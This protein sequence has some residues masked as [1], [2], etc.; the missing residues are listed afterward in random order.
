MI[1]LSVSVGAQTQPPDWYD[2]NAFTF[3][4][5]GLISLLP[6][7][8]AYG[9]GTDTWEVWVCWTPGPLVANIHDPER[10]TK[11]LNEESDVI[12]YFRWLSG[13]R[14]RP[15]F[16]VGGTVESNHSQQ[17]IRWIDCADRAKQA[18]AGGADGALII[19]TSSSEE[20]L[21]GPGE[22][23][24][25]GECGS[26][27]G[28]DRWAIVGGDAFADTY[29]HEIGHALHWPHSFSH[30][31]SWEYDNPMDVMGSPTNDG[32]RE[33]R[34]TPAVNRYAA[35]WIDPDEVATWHSAKGVTKFRIDPIGVSTTNGKQMVALTY[36]EDDLFDM[37]GA[38]VRGGYDLDIPKEG[39]EVYRVDQ[40]A[41]ACRNDLACIS[42]N[43]RIW[44]RGSAEAAEH[45]LGPGE[46]MSIPIIY[47][48]GTEGARIVTVK[49]RV[50]DS[51]DVV[52]GP[53]FDGT[54][55]D[56][57]GS[58]H[59]V[60][61][62]ALAQESITA[63]CDAD[64]DLFC[65]DRP[66]TRAQL[67]VLLIRAT[68]GETT[69]PPATGNVYSD[70]AADAWYARHVEWFARQAWTDPQGAFR[71]SDPAKRA[72]VAEFIVRL[73]PTVA[74]APESTG[75][76]ADVPADHP[77]IRSIESLA[78][79]DITKGCDTDPPRF[80]P[81]KPVTR[82]EIATFLVRALTVPDR[83][84]DV[85]TGSDTTPLGSGQIAVGSNHT[86]AIRSDGTV[87]C[88]G[89]NSYGQLDSPAGTF[90][91]V[92]AGDNYSCAIL[93]TDHSVICW[94]REWLASNLV[95]PAG[96]FI[97][98]STGANHACGLRTD[99]TVTCWGN[100]DSQ[101]TAA[102]TGTFSGVS[103][104]G[105]HSCGI[106][107]DGTAVC[108][109]SNYNGQ[110]DAPTGRFIAIAAGSGY[111]CGIRGI[112]TEGPVTCWGFDEYWRSRFEPPDGRF[113]AI[114]AGFPQTC[115]IRS[116]GT[117]S[118]WG[119]DGSRMGYPEGRFSAIAAGGDQTCAIRSDERIQ[120]WDRASFGDAPVEPYEPF[121]GFTTVTAGNK[122]SCALRSDGR[123]M[124]WGDRV[125][126]GYYD[127]EPSGRFTAVSAGEHHTCG[128][129]ADGTVAC[130]GSTSASLSNEPSGRFADIASGDGHA[131]AIRS[132]G[133][134]VCW[135]DNRYGQL[136]AP[137]GEYIHIT[138]G[139]RARYSCAIRTDG[140][141]TCW[142]R[143][144]NGETIAPSGRYVAIAAGGGHACA[145]RS[146][147]TVSCW[148]DNR[149]GQIDVPSGRF[150]TIAVGS[151][152]S[153]G[154]RTDNSLICWPYQPDIPTG[155]FTAVAVGLSHSCAVHTDGIVTCWGSNDRGQ[156]DPP[157]T[158]AG[159]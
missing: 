137:S 125:A 81:D 62:E 20:G 42:L 28:N 22:W 118:C 37:L 41:E 46:S 77:H 43:R 112:Q 102:P 23:C 24:R 18:S 39:V 105:G 114:A 139:S 157:M 36:T 85:P 98:V 68:E 151:G 128:I 136:S 111:S 82:A 52:I 126:R 1:V 25:A 144:R 5:H 138:S 64:F 30:G 87:V 89:S 91:A 101:Q 124:C 152:R 94:G 60:N 96:A 141:I 53:P 26:F 59:E 122:H 95:A 72:D 66:V 58:V 32:K 127:R 88:A 93:S 143:D 13:D 47:S 33:W 14:Y 120:C 51:F 48:D 155:R 104:G 57:D 142:G 31:S 50:E 34:A 65:P 35:G 80:C 129:R 76:F 12:P 3:D 100:N 49:R 79:A 55:R 44:Q 113:T 19:D 61:I 107:T 133:T 119:F 67:A 17:V 121:G 115:G 29:V 10:L 90:V 7:M 149:S 110:S 147:D 134:I 117:I 123:V 99:R 103:A 38:R 8:S 78:T 108:W 15:A 86:C 97:A 130:W 71:P 106:R 74:M 154:I 92:S 6:W 4:P 70:V 153:C 159:Q 56:D 116:D 16:R 11:W 54:F 140:T 9:S 2:E 148:G 21:A 109:G 83:E 150:M 27:P 146:D 156:A 135:G 45:V 40:R 145:I 69:L 75:R 73:L 131:C 132:D 158:I 84:S 63:G